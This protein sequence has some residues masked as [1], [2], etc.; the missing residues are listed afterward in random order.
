MNFAI[1][2][3]NVRFHHN[4]N[5]LRLIMNIKGNF[6][7]RFYMG[8]KAKSVP[9]FTQFNRVISD[10]MRSIHEEFYDSCFM[11]I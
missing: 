9:I 7:R 11:N 2:N 4:T 5:V 3:V 6:G 8:T 1:K 10:Y